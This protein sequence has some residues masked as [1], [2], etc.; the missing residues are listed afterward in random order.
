VKKV[1]PAPDKL[2]AEY[3]RSDFKKLKRGKYYAR[4]KGIKRPKQLKI[5]AAFRFQV[6]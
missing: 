6:H 2:R 4:V 3:K 1:K 5:T